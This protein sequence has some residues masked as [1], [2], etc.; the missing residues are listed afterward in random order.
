MMDNSTILVRLYYELNLL[1][2]LLTNNYTDN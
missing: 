2:P 1:Q